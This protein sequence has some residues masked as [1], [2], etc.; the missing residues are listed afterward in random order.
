M[1]PSQKNAYYYPWSIKFKPNS[2][3][4]CMRPKEHNKKYYNDEASL[5]YQNV[6]DWQEVV[7]VCAKKMFSA[8]VDREFVYRTTSYTVLQHSTLSYTMLHY[9]TLFYT[10]I[11]YRTHTIVHYCTL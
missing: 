8:L 2:S 6:N 11:H 3:R 10:M 1:L 5:C 4:G 7:R 9:F